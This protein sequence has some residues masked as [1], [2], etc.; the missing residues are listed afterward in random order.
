MSQQQFD[1]QPSQAPSPTSPPFYLS[2]LLPHALPHA[3]KLMYPILDTLPSLPASQLLRFLNTLTPLA[4]SSPSLF[5]PHLPALLR[6]LP[7]LILFSADPG[8][9]PTVARPFPPSSSGPSSGVF[10][11]SLS[12]SHLSPHSHSSGAEDG[13]QDEQDLEV[14]EV[15]KAVLEFMISLREAKPGMVMRTEGWV[16][17]FGQGVF[18]RDGGD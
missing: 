7:G 3:L 18:G 6:W 1:T 16:A 15:R 5:A 10:T 4:T 9:T 17:T 11:F 13:P 12:P 14:E 8:P 2:A